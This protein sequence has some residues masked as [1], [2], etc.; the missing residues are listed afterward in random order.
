MSLKSIEMQFA[1]HKNDEVGLK[2]HQLMNKPVLDQTVLS[3]EAGKNMLKERHVTA[4]T[5]QTAGPAVKDDGTRQQSRNK[6]HR[7][8]SKTVDQGDTMPERRRGHPFKGHH[9]DLSL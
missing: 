9:I 4:K 5:E 3:N 8:G 7:G 1:L 6:K 2:Q